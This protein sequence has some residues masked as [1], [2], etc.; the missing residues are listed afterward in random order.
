PRFYPAPPR[1]T[2]FR[3]RSQ[4]MMCQ[5]LRHLTKN[6]RPC[7]NGSDRPLALP[8]IGMV[9]RQ[10][11]SL[12]LTRTTPSNAEVLVNSFSEGIALPY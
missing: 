4:P 5:D 7:K 8:S 9:P 12:L 6:D 2:L 1:A 11:F 3:R 10:E